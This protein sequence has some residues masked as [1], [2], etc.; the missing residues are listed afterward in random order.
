MISNEVLIR[1]ALAL[2]GVAFG[3]GGAAV[4]MRR[5]ARD[6]NGLGRK[7]HRLV[8]L[9]TRWSAGDPEKVKQVADL[10]EGK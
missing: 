7:Y 9:L 8:A 6:L 5:A 2:M 1:T 3:A 10:I 4:Q